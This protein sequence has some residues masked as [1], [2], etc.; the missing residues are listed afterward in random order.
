MELFAEQGYESSAMI[1]IA[2]R[3]GLS[4]SVIY[5]HFPSKAELHRALLEREADA[6]LSSLAHSVPAPDASA[7]DV[8]LKAGI[9]A[10]FSY[11]R[12][13]PVAWQLLIRDAPTEPQLAATHRAIQ[14]RGT[15]AVAILIAGEHL[16]DPQKRQHKEMLA[17][18][19]KSALTG[20]ASWWSENSQVPQDEVVNTAF[21]FAWFGLERS[22]R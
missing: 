9:E 4:K 5:D 15:A 17:E 13:R 11:A 6:L 3:A 19:L 7:A 10:F 18:L 8:R 22:G 21:E 20:L 12:E 14:R 16:T 2:R 1:D